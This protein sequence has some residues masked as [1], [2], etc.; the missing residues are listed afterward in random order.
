VSFGATLSAIDK[1]SVRSRGGDRSNRWNYKSST[2][3]SN[4]N[5]P[6]PGDPGFEKRTM[7]RK[8]VLLK[9]WIFPHLANSTW[10]HCRIDERLHESGACMDERIRQKAGPKREVSSR[11]GSSVG[12]GDR[13]CS[14]ECYLSPCYW[15]HLHEGE[16]FLSHN[17]HLLQP[18]RAH[19]PALGGDAP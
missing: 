7:L 16:R 2:Q 5:L 18:C 6:T 14:R 9:S 13:C 1:N 11:A 8:S 3:N 19:R 4:H 12:R 17:H 15:S 10:P